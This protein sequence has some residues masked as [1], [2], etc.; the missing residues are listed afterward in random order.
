MSII[1]HLQVQLLATTSVSRVVY[2]F[3]RCNRQKTTRL[4]TIHCI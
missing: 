2:V 3:A 1:Y 4:Y